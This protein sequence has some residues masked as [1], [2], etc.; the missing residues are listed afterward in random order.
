MA[1]RKEPLRASDAADAVVPGDDGGGPAAPSQAAG[2]AGEGPAPVAP[3]R[4][5]RHPG[6]SRVM[7]FFWALLSVTIFA[8]WFVVTRFSV[9][10]Q[11]QIWD[12]SI[13]RFG[14]GAVVLTPVL[15]QRWSRLP[16]G[17][18]WRGL[19][20][21][22]LWGVPFVLLL[23]L[24]LKLTSAAQAASV[25]P[26]LMPVFAGVFAWA[27]LR[28]R[29]GRTRWLGFAA[30]IAGV[31]LLVLAG[32]VAHGA[33]S[34]A[35]LAALAGASAMWAIYTLFFRSS[36]LKAIEAAALICAWSTVLFL[37]PYLLL[38]LSRLSLAGPEEIA[39][40]VIY[41]GILVS[42][43]ALITFNQAVGQLGAGGAAATI[44]LLPGIATLLAVPILGESPSATELGAIAVIVGGVLLASRSPRG[45]AVLQVPKI[46]GR[47]P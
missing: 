19:I 1:I 20:F 5:A 10:R 23:A 14:V 21:S 47:G 26:T 39:L 32:A 41:Q 28:E 4:G 24:G 31:A 27:F 18:W 45:R 16:P 40:Q 30:I 12:I 44:A 8:G 36:G 34:L 3:P 15:I 38:G 25:A 7:G 6:G 37:P 13:L 43:V 33:P 17:S 29:Q 46:D 42:C 2:G 22:G 9:T 35:G 11:L